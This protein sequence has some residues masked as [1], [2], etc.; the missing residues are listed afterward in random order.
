MVRLRLPGG[1]VPAAA[2]RRLAELA[3]AYGNGVLQLTS[4]AGLQVRGLP[5]P[6]PPG[7]VQAVV[8]TGLLPSATHERVRNIVASPLTGLSG[9]LAD[10]TA[11]TASLDAG[12]VAEPTLAELGGRF[13]FVLD[14]GRGDVVDL[15]F[16][17][18]YQALG[19]QAGTVL[20]GS[21]ETG[22]A[23]RADDAVP[24]LI[25]LARGFAAARRETGAW[26]IRELPGWWHGLGA[27]SIAPVRGAPIPLGAIGAAASVSV[28]LA[29]LSLAQARVVEEA[30][31]G[32]PV[33]LTPWR[34]LVLPTAAD[35]LRDLAAAGLV[36]EE[37]S[38][39][40]QLSAC[41]G[42]PACGR[43]R[44]DTVAVAGG[45][46]GTARSLPRTHVSGCERRCGAPTG[47]HLDLVAP[48]PVAA[49]RA[50]E[51]RAAASAT[52]SER[53]GSHR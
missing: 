28:P 53:A 37:N 30:S 52:T 26:H 20:V 50:V 43:S 39:W 33:V 2:L 13:L 15:A 40:A 36:T 23:V 12:L 22:F 44:I 19:P 11:M 24:R 42:A 1:R 16:D 6:L 29:R 4:R 8:A 46:L 27:R 7:F 32:Q 49:V 3:G 45:L 34:G 17:L 10:V 48:T 51:E 25:D 18:A 38:P 31:A 14:D 35:R 5:D 9:G 47:D 41:V 21:P